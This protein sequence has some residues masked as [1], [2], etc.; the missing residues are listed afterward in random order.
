MFTAMKPTPAYPKGFDNV[1]EPAEDSFFLLDCLEKEEKFLRATA[2]ESLTPLVVA[3]LGSGTGIVSSIMPQIMDRKYIALAS[4]VNPSACNCTKKSWKMSWPSSSRTFPIQVIRGD[5]LDWVR[6]NTIDILLFNPPY[7]PSPS[8]PTRPHCVNDDEE[9]V[10]DRWVDLALDGGDQGMEITNLLL[11]QLHMKLS[12]KGIAYI[13]FCASNN[14]S[15]VC[16][17][18]ASRGWVSHHVDTRRAG[19]EVLSVYRFMKN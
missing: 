10:D 1:Y 6:P 13:L 15:K 2:G 4:D 9:L 11:K 14:P 12:E 18:M 8:V 16:L 19:R 17:E 3:E 5:L 7:V